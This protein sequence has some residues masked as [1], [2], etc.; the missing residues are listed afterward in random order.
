MAL[1]EIAVAIIV[2]FLIKKYFAGG[3]CKIQMDL[4]NQIVVVT[5]GNSGIGK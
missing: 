4:S 5:G 3:R 1:I 2:F